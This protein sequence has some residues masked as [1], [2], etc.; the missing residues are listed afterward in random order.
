MSSNHSF[1]AR[2]REIGAPRLLLAAMLLALA[3]GYFY[4]ARHLDP[5]ATYSLLPD[6]AYIPLRYVE[7]LAAGHGLV[8][9]IGGAPT[10]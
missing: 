5:S 10:S 9:N 4:N 2:V 7:N 3:I 8:W 6:D 1:A